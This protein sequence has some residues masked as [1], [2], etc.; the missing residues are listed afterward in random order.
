MDL[1]DIVA[2]RQGGGAAHKILCA[3]ALVLRPGGS[4]LGVRQ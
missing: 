4:G 2:G 3:T 1:F